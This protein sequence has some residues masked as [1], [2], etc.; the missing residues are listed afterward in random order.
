MLK[1]VRRRCW[2]LLV[3]QLLQQSGSF[4][5][6]PRFRISQYGKRIRSSGS[7]STAQGVG[8]TSE[9]SASNRSKRR[10]PKQQQ[11]RPQQVIH[12]QHSKNKRAHATGSFSITQQKERDKRNR[13]RFLFQKAKTMERSGQWREASEL[14]EEIL[15]DDPTDAHSHLALARL[16]AR[17][18]HFN[19]PDSKAR[20][21]FERGT[22]DCPNN[23]HLLQAWAR[24]EESCRN[25]TRAEELFEQALVLDPWNP[26]AC[27]AYG[28]MEKRLGNTRRAEELW[29]K[30]LEKKS[31]AALVC[32]LG[33]LWMAQKKYTQTQELYE[34]HLMK[35]QTERERTEVYLAWAWLE[36]KYLN[37]WERAEELIQLALLQSPGNSRA[38]VALSRLEERRD[39]GNTVGAK[40]RL[41]SACLQQ[42]ERRQDGASDGRLFNAWAH[43]EVKARKLPA[44]RKILLQGMKQFP[45]DQSLFQ[46]AGKV[47]ERIGNYTGARALYSTSLSI[48]PSAPTL[49]AYAM[50][51]LRHPEARPVN[52]TRIQQ[53][54]EEALLLDPR[55]GPAYNAYGNM[56]L[57][58]GKLNEA[59]AVYER[60]VKE[61]CSDPAS[62]FHG[63]AKLELSLG[64]VELAKDILRKG[65]QQVHEQER[66]MDS[67][68][69]E[70]AVF[71][72][73]TLG[74]LELNSNNA[75]EAMSVF[76]DGISRHGNSSQ[77]L[78]GAALCEIKLG[79]EDSA[80]NL[81]ERAVEADNRH[82]QA[83]QAWGVMEMRAGN[84]TT[85]KSLF[86]SGLRSAPK[87]GALWQ[88]YANMEGRLGNLEHAR[89]LFGAGIKKSPQHV[90]LYQGWASLEL[91]E[92]NLEVAKRLISEA[93]TRDKR[94]AS[95]WLVAAQIEE[96]QGNDGL[97]GLF[98]RRGIECAPNDAEL[99]RALGDHLVSKGSIN[100][101]REIFEKGLEVNP[102]HAPL[103]HSL[104]ELEARIFN[105]EGLRLLNER[106]SKLFNNDALAPSS[107]SSKALGERIRKGSSR[108]HAATDVAVLSQKVG[109]SVEADDT[110]EEEDTHSS[111]ESMSRLEDEVVNVV[112]ND[113]EI[114]GRNETGKL[115]D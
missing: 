65:L 80:R 69:S 63:L 83:W 60:G 68:K 76:Q 36:E 37:S 102:L 19:S 87:H 110:E 72:A 8:G 53:I 27:H 108:H 3:L 56:E 26:Y 98:L 40:R 32:S 67:S 24:Y 6:T 89:V 99:Y 71:L 79:K 77:L 70:R 14:L 78:L 46:A 39:G 34:S 81:F 1:F 42:Q 90:P 41:A 61:Q 97:V 96:R 21:A 47:E 29:Q 66:F 114:T 18:E 23:V 75:A 91:R 95:G 101:A 113:H 103:Y 86:E 44:A 20:S 84:Y 48:E 58:R 93:L 45:R 59:R 31:T 52:F 13:S 104:A 16:E 62:V 115:L 10:N 94:H 107:S 15:Q 109:E 2:L 54:F 57:R 7:S 17:R 100:V 111:I 35:I 106:A 105:L 49:V 22:R 50:L 11:Q 73:H 82:A 43:L 112:F 30:A 28:L 38:L 4:T 5:V 51:E 85:A 25:M 9:K 74:M 55:H 64:N 92:G 12:Q 88:A 33:D